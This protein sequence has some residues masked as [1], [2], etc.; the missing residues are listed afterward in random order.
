[1]IV[2]QHHLCSNPII[3]ED[4]VWLGEGIAVLAGAGIGRC[5]IIGAHAVVTSDIPLYTNSVEKPE[6]PIKMYCF[7]IHK[8]IRIEK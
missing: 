3:I 4:T 8:L 2:G 5:S 7:S 1:M 6:K